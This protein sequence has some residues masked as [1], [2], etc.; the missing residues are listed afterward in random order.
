[1]QLH[2]V[3]VVRQLLLQRRVLGDVREGAGRA[4]RG[5]LLEREV[6]LE[7]ERG[8]L[9]NVLEAVVGL[10]DG[11]EVRE[12]VGSGEI[13][14]GAGGEGGE[15]GDGDGRGG[16]PPPDP[17]RI[18]GPGGGGGGVGEGSGGGGEGGGP[19]EVGGRRPSRRRRIHRSGQRGR[20]R[21]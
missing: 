16:G 14:G 2:H 5:P 10:G 19:G 6:L 21:S 17:G 15:V 4:E 1:M 20:E 18:G 8:D 12:E 11:G 9:P 13:G 3:Q 7:V